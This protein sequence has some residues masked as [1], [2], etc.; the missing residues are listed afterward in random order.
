MH[1]GHTRM[2][3]A[4]QAYKSNVPSASPF[5]PRAVSDGVGGGGGGIER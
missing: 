2:D 5:F 4:R 1:G 3:Q